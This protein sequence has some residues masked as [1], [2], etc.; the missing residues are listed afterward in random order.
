[1]GFKALAPDVTE[2]RKPLR[3]AYVF[4]KIYYK[5]DCEG[6]SAVRLA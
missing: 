2:E 3:F 5:L 4:S 6:E 1:M